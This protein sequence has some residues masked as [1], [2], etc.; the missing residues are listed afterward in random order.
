MV[1]DAS[2]ATPSSKV[3]AL[4]IALHA[5]AKAEPNYRFYSLWD[6]VSPL[7]SDPKKLPN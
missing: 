3:Q 2:L 7:K 1:I 6:K 5:K 4:Q